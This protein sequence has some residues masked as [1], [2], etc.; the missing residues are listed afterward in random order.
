MPEFGPPSGNKEVR[1]YAAILAHSF[2]GKPDDMLQ[3]LAQLSEREVRVWRE[4]RHVTAGVVAYR[5]GQYF[6]GRPVPMAGVAGVVVTPHARATGAGSKAMTA[7]L[8]ELHAEGVALSTLYPATQPIYRRLGYELAGVRT[9]YRVPVGA[10]ELKRQPGTLR[11]APEEE[12]L[13]DSLARERAKQ[14]NGHLERNGFFWRRLWG[15]GDDTAFRYIIE[16]EG[17]PAGFLIYRTKRTEFPLQDL[18]VADWWAAND[19]AARRLLAFFGEHRSVGANVQI[20]GAPME[21]LLF[22]LPEQKWKV[23]TRWE[24]MTRIVHLPAALQ[25][26]GYPVTAEL[27]IEL[28]IT[29]D[30]LAD[31]QGRWRLTLEKGKGRVSRGGSGR[32]KLDIRGLAALY[33]SALGPS[34]LARLGYLEARVADQAALAQAFAGPAP[35]LPD[36]F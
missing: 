11:P 27:E 23:D 20:F 35:W 9:G 19:K 13:F 14:A 12:Q 24:W 16:V 1:D 30:V 15:K 34:D 26:R 2:A 22:C 36:F 29:D 32:V 31:N 5:I 25:A 4:G 21:P 10:C 7:L 6:G 3:W 8:R 33:S 18:L 17:K 28:D